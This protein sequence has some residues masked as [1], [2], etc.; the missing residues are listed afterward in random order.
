MDLDILNQV[1]YHL[2]EFD[3]TQSSPINTQQFVIDALTTAF[4]LRRQE[5]LGE[6][7]LVVQEYA[8]NAPGPPPGTG[9]LTLSSGC[10]LYTSRCV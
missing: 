2:L 5:I 1:G 4:S 7:R 9:R 8:G 10:L 3:G 6:T